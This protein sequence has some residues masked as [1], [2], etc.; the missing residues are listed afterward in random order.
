MS[1][2]AGTREKSVDEVREALS[3]VCSRRTAIMGAL[4]TMILLGYAILR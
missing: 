2:Q 4:F 3:V 1:R